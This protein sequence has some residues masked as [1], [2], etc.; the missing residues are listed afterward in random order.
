M[1]TCAGFPNPP[2]RSP[3]VSSEPKVPSRA[4]QFTDPRS[5]GRSTIRL[6]KVSLE[7]ACEFKRRV[8]ALIACIGTN[9]GPDTQLLFGSE[10]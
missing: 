10:D 9:T 6:G 4:I 1:P 8:E 2:Y 7:A 3:Y 5:G